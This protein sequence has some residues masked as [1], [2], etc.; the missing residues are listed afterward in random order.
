MAQKKGHSATMVMKLLF[1][2]PY[3]S[4]EIL[5]NNVFLQVHKARPGITYNF[6]FF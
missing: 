6:Y 4:Y 5:V 3:N 1:G 2:T